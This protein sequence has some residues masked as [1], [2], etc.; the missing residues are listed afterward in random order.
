[1]GVKMEREKQIKEMA[2]DLEN[3][4]CMSKI[5]AEIAIDERR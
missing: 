3:Y 2:C 1:M 4:T 5:Q